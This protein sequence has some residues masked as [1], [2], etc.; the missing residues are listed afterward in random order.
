MPQKQELANRRTAGTLLDA[1]A[2]RREQFAIARTFRDQVLAIPAR[3]GPELAGLGSDPKAI[4]RRLNQAL[5][6]ALFGI[7]KILEAEMGGA[8]PTPA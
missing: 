8:G 6:E 3:L 4:T 7:V 5:R 1:A 2:A